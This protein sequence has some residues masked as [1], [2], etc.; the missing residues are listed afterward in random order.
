MESTKKLSKAE[1]IEAIAFL[2][3]SRWR[4]LTTEECVRW[5]N[6]LKYIFKYIEVD[7]SVEYELSSRIFYSHNLPEELWEKSFDEVFTSNINYENFY[8]HSCSPHFKVETITQIPSRMFLVS[9]HPGCVGLLSAIYWLDEETIRF[10]YE[11]VR[12]VNVDEK[13]TGVSWK[14]LFTQSECPEDILT[15]A[16]EERFNNWYIAQN[17]SLPESLYSHFIKHPSLK[18]RKLFAGNRGISKE[19]LKYLSEKDSARTVREIAKETLETL[20]REKE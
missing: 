17:P 7:A 10:F 19:A 8:L 1:I 4:L 12:N 2:D 3:E 16:L 6:R 9:T 13:Y 5:F 14:N 20:D 18:V 15:Q 11:R